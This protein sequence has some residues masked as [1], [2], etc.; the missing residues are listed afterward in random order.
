MRF[1]GQAQ[2]T[3]FQSQWRLAVYSYPH[4]SLTRALGTPVL[5]GH[6]DGTAAATHGGRDTQTRYCSHRCRATRASTS[7]CV[8]IVKVHDREERIVPAIRTARGASGPHLQ[9][10]AGG[11]RNVRLIVGNGP[12][13]SASIGIRRRS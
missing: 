8:H 5:D 12:W 9:M 3:A 4:A 6:E 13:C 2:I 1:Y 11:L 10:H 7:S